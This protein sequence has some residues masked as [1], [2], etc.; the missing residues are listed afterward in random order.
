M[1]EL[2]A[3]RYRYWHIYVLHSY[4]M[5]RFRRLASKTTKDT[6][7]THDVLYLNEALFHSG[8]TSQSFLR[9]F[10]AQLLAR[11]ILFRLEFYTLER[12]GHKTALADVLSGVDD[13]LFSFRSTIFPLDV[14]QIFSWVDRINYCEHKMEC[15]LYIQSQWH[16]ELVSTA[17]FWKRELE[18]QLHHPHLAGFHSFHTI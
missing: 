14:V 4:W 2:T 18:Y 7:H 9:K 3:N 11:A 12:T 5:I 15:C 16:D 1:V 13:E 6:Y 8:R 10:I 17:K